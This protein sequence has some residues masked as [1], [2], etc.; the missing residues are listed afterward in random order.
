CAASAE[1]VPERQRCSA[2][3]TSAREVATRC[4]ISAVTTAWSRAMVFGSRSII[5]GGLPLSAGPV[6]S[7]ANQSLDQ[8]AEHLGDLFGHRDCDESREI[9]NRAHDLTF[10]RELARIRTE[11]PVAER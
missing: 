10:G 11:D 4:S 7:K 2:F 8:V 1:C 6:K 9:D 3:S 5:A